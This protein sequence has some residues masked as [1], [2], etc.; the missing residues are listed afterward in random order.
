MIRLLVSLS[1]AVSAFAAPVATPSFEVKFS[2]LDSALSSGAPGSGLSSAF[3]IDPSSKTRSYAYF[4]TSA[5]DLNAKGW[6]VRLRH[7]EGKDLE[8]TYKVRCRV[9]EA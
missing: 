3:G 1:L 6:A 7:K 4:D 2:L 5:K 8:L 9:R